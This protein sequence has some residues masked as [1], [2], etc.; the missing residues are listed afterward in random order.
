MNFNVYD[1][2]YS[3]FSHQYASA[4]I[5]AIFKVILLQDYKNTNV[6]CCVSVTLLKLFVTE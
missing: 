4:G 2:L 1:E 3:Q 5:A 6:I